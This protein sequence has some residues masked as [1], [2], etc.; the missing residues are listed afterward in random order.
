MMNRNEIL[1]GLQLSAHGAQLTWY[2]NELKEPQTLS[3]PGEMD[4]GL[5]EVPAEVWNALSREDASEKASGYIRELLDMVPQLKSAEKHDVR[6]CVTVPDLDEKMS[7]RLKTVVRQAG[8]DERGI[9][10][11]DFRTSFFYYVVNKKKE[12]WN[13]DVAFLSVQDGRMNGYI[14]HIDRT[15]SPHTASF[16]QEA[17]CD[18]SDKARA[19]RSDED[20]DAERDRLLYELLGKLFERRNVSAS[21]LYGG[22]FDARWAKRSFQYL[23][24]HRHAFQGQNL[25][26]KGAC[27]GVM[28]RCGEIRM[29]DIIFQGVDMVKVNIGMKVRVKGRPE[30][31]PLIRAGVN[32]YEAYG[33]L[34]VVPESEKNVT[35]LSEDE[36]GSGTIRHTLRLDHFPD[37]PDRASRL[38]VRVWFS[39]PKMLEAEVTDLGF[40]SMYPSSGRIWH[41]SIRIA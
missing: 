32:W 31:V 41:R 34:D 18:V 6:I 23:T 12:L 9:F 8:V 28:A 3:L 11:Q 4:N 29:P 7:K 33:M 14:L 5:M 30:T 1:I 22:Y 16:R 40:G 27:Y 10:L 26:S 2:G 38:R 13:G 25:F 35:I 20:W 36:D 24:F 39:A 19:G 17:S 15:A 37:R 21:Y